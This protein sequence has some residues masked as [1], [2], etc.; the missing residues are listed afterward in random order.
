MLMLNNAYVTTP[1]VWLITVRP[2]GSQ[3]VVPVWFFWDSET[4]L[5]CSQPNAQKVR[6]L[7][8]NP[9]VMLAFDG[10]GK[11]GYDVVVVEGRQNCSMKLH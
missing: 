10:A 11:L 9:N 7:R 3:H 4:F 1:L 2:D 6:N 8:H 5:I